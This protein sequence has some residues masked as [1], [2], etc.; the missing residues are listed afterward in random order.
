MDPSRINRRGFLGTVGATA[1]GLA[2]AA[3][4]TLAAQAQDTSPAASTSG[5]HLEVLTLTPPRIGERLAALGLCTF[6]T[7]D[8]EARGYP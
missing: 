2:F 5:S 3:Q 6:L 4:T 8:P 1:T 7:F